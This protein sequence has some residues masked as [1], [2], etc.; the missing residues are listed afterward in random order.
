MKDTI[1]DYAMPCMNAERAL[2][3]AHNAVLENDYDA[4]ISAAMRATGECRL[5]VVSL[6]GMKEQ[7]NALRKQATS[8]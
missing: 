5:L 1:V 8:V 3:E 4:A 2:K 6:K 7:Q